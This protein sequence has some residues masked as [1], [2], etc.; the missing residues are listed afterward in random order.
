MAAAGPTDHAAL[1]I[2]TAM[3][4]PDKDRAMQFSAT[5]RLKRAGLD[6]LTIAWQ[7]ARYPS[8][9]LIVQLWIHVQAFWLFYKGVPYQPHPDGAET[10]ASRLIGAVM[11]PLFQI[12]AWWSG[13]GGDETKTIES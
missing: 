9:C 3:I 8:F 11:T 4:R 12:Q 2:T 1:R 6:P 5:L 13:D 10:T 7:L